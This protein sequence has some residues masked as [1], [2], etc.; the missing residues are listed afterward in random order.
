ME[1]SLTISDRE[2]RPQVVNLFQY[3]NQTTT[4]TITLDSYMHG[5]VDLR[6]YTAYAVTSQNGLI[7]YTELESSMVDDKLTLTWTVGEYSLRQEGAVLFQI[8]FKDISSSGEPAEGENTAVFYSYKAI[9]V[10]RGSVDGD[11][12][13][14]ANY[15]TLLKQWLDKMAANK[16][17]LTDYIN[18]LS[19]SFNACIVYIPYGETMPVDQRLAG[20]LYYQILNNNTFDGQFEDHNGNILSNDTLYVANANLNE[21]LQNKTYVCA[22]TMKNTPIATTYCVVNVYDSGSTNRIIQEASVPENDNTVRVFVRAI[23]GTTTFGEWT[24]LSSKNYVDD[25][26]ETLLMLIDEKDFEFDCLAKMIELNLTKMFIQI[27]EDTSSIDTTKGDGAYCIENYYN[28]DQHI[29]IK[30]DDTTKTIYSV[31]KVVTNGNNKAWCTADWTDLGEGSL[32]LEIS[33]DGGTT[34]STLPQ[35]SLTTIS[36]Q[37]TGVSMILKVTATGKMKLKNLAWGMKT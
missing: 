2:I 11:N 21:L 8:V 22:G 28:A 13:I 20:R 1:L 23:T 31:R 10:N 34:W 9:I 7:D 14:T 37:P 32:T 12:H 15:P 30:N 5:E 27:F 24:E 36:S 35:N 17:E 3:E 25:K 18:G 4:L 16:Q 33:R 6:N 29:F 19:S 26:E